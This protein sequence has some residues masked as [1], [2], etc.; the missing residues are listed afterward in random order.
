LASI[1]DS[2][3][4]ELAEILI[5]FYFDKKHEIIYEEEEDKQNQ[6]KKKNKIENNNKIHEI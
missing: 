3:S 1:I 4:W 5:G 2:V 6:K